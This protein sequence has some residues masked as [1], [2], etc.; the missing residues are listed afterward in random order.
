MK[1][2]CL[3]SCAQIVSTRAVTNGKRFRPEKKSS[4]KRSEMRKIYK[5]IEWKMRKKRGKAKWK[6]ISIDCWNRASAAD[7]LA[8]RCRW[9]ET[10]TLFLIVSPSPSLPPSDGK[11]K[12]AATKGV[13]EEKRVTHSIMWLNRN[14]TVDSEAVLLTQLCAFVDDEC[15]FAIV[16][17]HW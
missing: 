15:L 14:C 3:W 9:F 17:D 13:R 6:L 1:H 4:Q 7:N 8:R 12:K 11:G 16:I 2:H 5:W 10:K